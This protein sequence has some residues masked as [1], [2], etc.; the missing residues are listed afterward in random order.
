MA[1]IIESSVESQP[2]STSYSI[3]RVALIGLS[4]GVFYW[5][6]TMILANITDS[7]SVVGGVS[8]ILTATLGV[9]MMMY[10]HI[11]RPLIVALASAVSLWGLAGWVDGLGWIEVVLWNLILFTAT[12]VLFSWLS[13]Y[14]RVV[15][16]FIVIMTIV[17]LVRITSS[18]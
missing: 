1:K 11:A 12:Y 18:L 6:L 5:A 7:V 16:V 10:L 8:M 15:T 4:L 9:L 17:V 2:I 14:T 3:C 13:R